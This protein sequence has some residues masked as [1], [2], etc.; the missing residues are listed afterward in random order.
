[1]CPTQA[2]PLYESMYPAGARQARAPA[3][4]RSPLV[5]VDVGVRQA[6]VRQH[7]HLL[8]LGQPP[9]RRLKRLI[10]QI[11][12]PPEKVRHS[13]PVACGHCVEALKAEAHAHSAVHDRADRHNRPNHD[14]CVLGD[15]VPLHERV[16]PTPDREPVRP[17]LGGKPLQSGA[18]QSAEAAPEHPHVRARYPLKPHP[19]EG[20]PIDEA[21]GL[22]AHPIVE[23][24]LE[25]CRT[26]EE[27][28]GDGIID[29]P[30]VW[31]QRAC[32]ELVR[33]C[34]PIP[35]RALRR[36]RHDA[37]QV[38]LIPCDLQRQARLSVVNGRQRHVELAPKREVH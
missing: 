33:L 20:E 16:V 24:L 19:C 8:P 22:E 4:A 17:P 7:A 38:P 23:A 13:H 27:R 37:Q 14:L 2:R 25:T 18:W 29:H 28:V 21:L 36:P 9:P 34:R 32:S 11:R 1:M 15:A 12:I 3:R 10:P 30:R 31:Q 6:R 26:P 35:R 5:R